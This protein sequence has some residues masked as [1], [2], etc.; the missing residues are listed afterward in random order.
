MAPF[1][2]LKEDFSRVQFAMAETQVAQVARVAGEHC[3]PVA[4]LAARPMRC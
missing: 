4:L 2:T 1:S 3:L